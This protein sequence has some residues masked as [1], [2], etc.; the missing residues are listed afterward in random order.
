MLEQ[1]QSLTQRISHADLSIQNIGNCDYV[2]DAPYTRYYQFR[3]ADGFYEVGS[4]ERHAPDSFSFRRAMKL[5][6][7]INSHESLEDCTEAPR[8]TNNWPHR[9]A[10]LPFS[11]GGLLS[12]QIKHFDGSTLQKIMIHQCTFLHLNQN[13]TLF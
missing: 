9:P 3:F 7:S 10:G 2:L 6:P 12:G 11:W 8:V 5:L 13:P 4:Y 1:L